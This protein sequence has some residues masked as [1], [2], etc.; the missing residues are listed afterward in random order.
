MVNK[1]LRIFFDQCEYVKMSIYDNNDYDQ[2]YKSDMLCGIKKE[3]DGVKL[4]T[5]L[6]KA[7]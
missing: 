1:I 7:P 4:G 5:D 2:Y 6:S 3:K